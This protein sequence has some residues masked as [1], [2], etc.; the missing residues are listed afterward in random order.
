MKNGIQIEPL[1]VTA[2]EWTAYK[3]AKTKASAAEREA[4][5]FLASWGIPDASEAAKRYGLTPGEKLEL[6]VHDGNSQAIG[7]LTISYRDPETEPR[8][9]FWTKRLS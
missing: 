4:N 2:A 1:R 3:L 8:P 9:G 5:A 6:P 7:K